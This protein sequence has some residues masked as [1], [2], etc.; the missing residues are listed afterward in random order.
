M[1]RS[2]A[3]RALVP[4]ALGLAVLTAC[5]VNLDFS[6][7]ISGQAVQALET[8]NTI[9]SAIVI[10]FSGQPDIQAHKSS[11]ESLSLTALDMTVSAVQTDNTIETVTGTLSLRPDGAT[12][13]SQDVLVGS[14]TAFPITLGSGIHLVGSSALDAFAL[15]TVQGTER[16][17]AIISGT[18]TGGFTADFSVDLQLTM[19]MG[20][21][22]SEL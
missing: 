18:T 20:Y 4:S 17:T 10:D 19:S 22:A 11:I 6:Y 3:R 1:T 16:C 12:D 13:A 21:D 5:V 2:S 15:A 7:T 9:N 14:L 8:S